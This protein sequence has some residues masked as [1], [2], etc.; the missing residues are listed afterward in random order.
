MKSAASS[1][2]L[3]RS[4]AAMSSDLLRMLMRR[5]TGRYRA[6]ASHSRRRHVAAASARPIIDAN[7]VTTAPSARK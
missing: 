1:V 6:G 2:R 7:K 3:I 5:A 4:A